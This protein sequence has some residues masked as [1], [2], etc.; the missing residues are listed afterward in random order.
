[1]GWASGRIEIWDTHTKH[2][3]SRFKS[4]FGEPQHLQ[5]HAANQQLAITGSGGKVAFVEVPSGKKLRE[6]SIPLGERRYD[7]HELAF[8]PQGKWMAY[9]DEES[10]KVLNLS[11]S[12]PSQLADLKDAGSLALSLDGATLFTVNRNELWAFNTANWEVIGHWPHKSP[13]INTASV[14]VR[15]GV[16]KDGKGVVAVP[17]ANGLVIYREPEMS[18]EFATDKPTS[19]VGFARSGQVFVN[20]SDYISL[21]TA[22][23]GVLCRR[24]YKGRRDYAISEDG[25]WLALW[26]DNSINL[27]RIGDL[28][29]QCK[30]RP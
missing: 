11:T 14:L 5:F 2:R 19:A 9:A 3:V 17:S 4:P 21:L 1:M 18:G 7:I 20:L 22:D 25:Q 29:E 8:D 26:Q 12:T 13:P 27:W 28:L 6:F 16:T 15:A 23:G 10:S 24:F 30:A